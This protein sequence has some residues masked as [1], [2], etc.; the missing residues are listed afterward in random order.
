MFPVS[1]RLA[2]V[3]VCAARAATAERPAPRPSPALGYYR[4]PTVSPRGIVFTAE[5]DLWR[6]PL[7]GGV[8]RSRQD[9][10]RGERRSL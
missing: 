6:V 9:Q 2:A 5:G 7:G 4:F 1:F 8:A 10:R 3:L